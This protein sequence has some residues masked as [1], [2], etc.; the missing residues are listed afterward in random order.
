MRHVLDV[1]HIEKNIAESVLKFLFGEKD[2]LDS[3]RDLEQ[4][5]LRRELWLHPG[6]NGQPFLKPNAPYVFSDA[7][8]KIFLD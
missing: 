4:V 6:R 5:G 8:K 2:S 3:R 7:E 1:M